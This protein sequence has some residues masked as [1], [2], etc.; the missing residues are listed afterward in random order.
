[1][2][3][4]DAAFLE[5][6][7]VVSISVS[8]LPS[9]S[10]RQLCFRIAAC[11]FCLFILFLFPRYRSQGRRV[12]FSRHGWFR[13]GRW[14]SW[15]NWYFTFQS[16]YQFQC[17]LFHWRVFVCSAMPG[18]P[19]SH[20]HLGNLLNEGHERTH[21]RWRNSQKHD[22]CKIANPFTHFPNFTGEAWPTQSS[23]NLPHPSPPSPHPSS[24]DHSRTI[25]SCEE[26]WG[27]RGEGWG[28]LSN[29]AEWAT[30]A[31]PTRN[32][33]K[34]GLNKLYSNKSVHNCCMGSL[35]CHCPNSGANNNNNNNNK[36]R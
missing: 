9:Q 2:T 32:H 1:M 7:V 4:S 25:W 14:M 34:L 13:F 22:I 5:G 3:N 33:T 6:A 8:H 18:R 31:R 23:P 35:C 30:I 21:S 16:F 36:T 10:V 11:S 17:S 26:G 24:H 29:M 20:T 19:P 12:A 15:I 27:E 28:R